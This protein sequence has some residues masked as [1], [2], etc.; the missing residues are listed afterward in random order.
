MALVSSFGSWVAIADDGEATNGVLVGGAGR[1]A[2]ETRWE[3]EE[4]K[5]RAVGRG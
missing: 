5:R 1:S 4:S 2:E 3:E